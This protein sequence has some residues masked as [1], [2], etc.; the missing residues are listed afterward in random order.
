MA[1]EISIPFHEKKR[2]YEKKRKEKK[3]QHVDE[4]REETKKK[5]SP[6]K[7]FVG[8]RVMAE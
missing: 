1:E 3:T 8:R 4:V 5:V 2:D 6:E 7:I